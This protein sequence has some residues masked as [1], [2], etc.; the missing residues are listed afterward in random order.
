MGL[1]APLFG[2][3]LGIASATVFIYV[4]IWFLASIVIGRLDIIDIAWGPGFFISGGV[5]YLFSEYP[6]NRGLL[7]LGLVLIWGIRLAL[8]IGCRNRR[9]QEDFRYKQWREEWGDFVYVRSYFQVFIIQGIVM[10]IASLSII[11]IESF[12]QPPINWMDGIGVAVLFI[13]FIFETVGDY[14]L[15]KFKQ[16]VQNKGK[17]MQTGLWKYTRHPNYFGEALLWWGIYIIACGVPY[18]W[19]SFISPLCITLLVRFVSGVP[20]LEQKFDKNSEFQV[21][22]RRTPVFVPWCPKSEP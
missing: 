1:Y 5:V 3:S 12:P 13:G 11:L 20:L 2:E 15:S 8:H 6:S 14:Q 22:K 7:T 10:V 19:T 4:N 21:Y 9:Q 17:F 16:D 18:G